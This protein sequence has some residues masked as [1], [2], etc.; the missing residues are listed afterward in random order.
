M[1]VLINSLGC[2][3]GIMLKPALARLGRFISNHSGPLKPLFSMNIDLFIK[4]LGYSG[5][6]FFLLMLF[7]AGIGEYVLTKPEPLLVPLL[8]ISW[9]AIAA[10][11]AWALMRKKS[12]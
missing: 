2:A 5:F 11:Y 10:H 6:M 8:L 7:G 1:S 4:W 3:V 12:S 9:V